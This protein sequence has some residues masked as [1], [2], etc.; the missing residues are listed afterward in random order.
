MNKVIPIA[1]AVRVGAIMSKVTYVR[2]PDGTNMPEECEERTAEFSLV[3]AEIELDEKDW[4][5]ISRHICTLP[6]KAV[7]NYE[8]TYI[9]V[10]L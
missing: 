7:M 5:T 2:T 4:D 9:S 3:I 10:V 6:I 1:L 8:Y